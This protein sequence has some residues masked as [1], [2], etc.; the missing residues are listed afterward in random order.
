MSIRLLSVVIKAIRKDKKGWS[1]KADK[2]TEAFAIS[3]LSAVCSIRP[4]DR[5]VT[6][7][8]IPD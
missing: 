6:G 8:Q 5:V 3:A 4:V 7:K 1:P 2:D